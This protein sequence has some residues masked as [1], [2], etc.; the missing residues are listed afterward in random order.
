[1]FK[2]IIPLTVGSMTK[3]G[4]QTSPV[5]GGEVSSE[6]S[7][8][9]TVTVKVDVL[10]LIGLLKYCEKARSRAEMQDFCEIKS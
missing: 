8:E 9:V 2:I 5:A 7:G 6:V 4:Q 1:M 10:K 3:V